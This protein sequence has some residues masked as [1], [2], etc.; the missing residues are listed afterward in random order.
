MLPVLCPARPALVETFAPLAAPE[1]RHRAVPRTRLVR[2]L[3]ETDAPIA[4]VI[5]PAGYGKT[6]LIAEWAARDARPFTWLPC[7]IDDAAAQVETRLVAAIRAASPQVMVADD[8]HGLAYGRAAPAQHGLPAPAWRH[9]VVVARGRVRPARSAGCAPAACCSSSRRADLALS[10]LEAAMLV[11]AAEPAGSNRAPART[12]A[13]PHRRLAGMVYLAAASLA[14]ADDLGAAI[15]AFTGADRRVAE[16]LRDEVLGPSRRPSGLP[17]PDV[18]PPAA[19]RP[20]LR[21]GS[22]RSGSGSKL[23]ALA[24]AGVPLEPLDRTDLAFR[25]HPLL[26]QMLRTELGARSTSATASCTAAPRAGSPASGDPATAIEPR[27]RVRRRAAGR[28]A[29]WAHAPRAAA[30]GRRPSAS[31]STP[32][33]GPR[34]P[35]DFALRRPR[36]QHL[37]RPAGGPPEPRPTSPSVRSRTPGS[38]AATR[39]SRCCAPAWPRTARRGGRR[40]RSRARAVAAD[41]PVAGAGPAA[42]GRR[43]PPRRRPEAAGAQL[44]E[45]AGRAGAALAPIVAAV[46]TA[47]LALL[48]AEAGD[49]DEAAHRALGALVGD[50]ARPRRA[51]RAFVRRRRRSSP[52]TAVRS[53]APATTPPTR[54]GCSPPRADFPPWLLSEAQLWLAARRSSSATARPGAAAG[55]HRAPAAAGGQAALLPQWIHDGWARAD[56]FAESA[57]GDGP[58]LTNAEL[59]VLRLLPSHM[60]FREIGER[61]HVSTNT[62]KTQALAVYRKLDVSCRSDAVP[63]GRAAG[64]IGGP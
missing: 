32:S 44:L 34:L 11:E 22:A 5:A 20:G 14:G 38:P 28:P 48:A 15:A 58:T 26:A 30:A 24:R 16:F 57:T 8:A 46:A 55:A 51:L 36:V 52:R 21:R 6:T 43:A 41:E 54:T 60:S 42:A 19:D 64:L 17:A 33:A 25:Q 62:V 39:R 49:W 50:S 63:R 9:A 47:Q 59:R 4:L 45:A 27:G 56:A 10:P 13:R 23:A 37:V 7:P 35:D 29:A 1:P 61:L 2:R 12:P 31:G 3:T 18:D 53:P 40:R